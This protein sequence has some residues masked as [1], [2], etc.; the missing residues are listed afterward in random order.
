MKPAVKIRS[1]GRWMVDLVRLKAEIAAGTLTPE[2]RAFVERVLP[3]FCDFAAGKIK[4][5]PPKP[6]ERSA[7]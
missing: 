2:H 7:A 4:S 6:E 3:G 1:N 5:W